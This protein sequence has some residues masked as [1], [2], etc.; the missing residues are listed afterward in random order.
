MGLNKSKSLKDVPTLLVDVRSGGA[1]GAG[2]CQVAEDVE[3]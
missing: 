3:V 2:R 1:F